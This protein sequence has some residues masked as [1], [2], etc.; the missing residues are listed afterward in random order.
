MKSRRQENVY[1]TLTT[2]SRPFLDMAGLFQPGKAIN[3][4]SL[5]ASGSG[6]YQPFADRRRAVPTR[7]CQGS[8][9]SNIPRVQPL[10]HQNRDRNPGKSTFREWFT[11]MSHYW[12]TRVTRV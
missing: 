1:R 6:C 9:H 8:V 3:D 11:R 5:C 10:I 7:H 12:F 2:F 4:E